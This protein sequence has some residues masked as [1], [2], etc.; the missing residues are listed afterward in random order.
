MLDY[1]SCDW[2]FP[3]EANNEIAYLPTFRYFFVYVGLVEIDVSYN[4]IQL[5]RNLQWESLTALQKF[6][7]SNNR[8]FDP[9]II[10][11]MWV[12]K[13]SKVKK[14]VDLETKCWAIENQIISFFL[15]VE[16]LPRLCYDMFENI[17]GLSPHKCL[18]E[19]ILLVIVFHLNKRHHTNVAY[20]EQLCISYWA[21]ALWV[22]VFATGAFLYSHCFSRLSC[23]WVLSIKL[24]RCPASDWRPG[25]GEV[26]TPKLL[27][28]IETLI[29]SCHIPH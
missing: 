24:G 3:D 23:K 16:I 14:E 1:P 29:S 6:Y 19:I 15:L 11:K 4:R 20:M 21:C 28:V 18:S 26:T 22:R 10:T 2:D 17:F 27:H 8:L 5:L 12:R 25:Q 13:L 9:E 7:M